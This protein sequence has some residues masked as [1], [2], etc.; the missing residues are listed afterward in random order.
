MN[1]LNRDCIFHLACLGIQC[2]LLKQ[3]KC[4]ESYNLEKEIPTSDKPI[5]SSEEL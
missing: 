4:E 3:C 5:E 1:N 2:C